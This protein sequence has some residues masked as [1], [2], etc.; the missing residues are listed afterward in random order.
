VFLRVDPGSQW[1]VTDRKDFT[2]DP[3]EIA[4]MLDA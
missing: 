4:V 2:R 3:G 1:Q